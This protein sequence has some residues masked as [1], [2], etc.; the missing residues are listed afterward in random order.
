M[1]QRDVE[2]A[3]ADATVSRF[4]ATFVEP[5]AVVPVYTRPSTEEELNSL[6]TPGGSATTQLIEFEDPAD[7]GSVCELPPGVQTVKPGPAFRT[8]HCAGC[9]AVAVQFRWV[10]R[11]GEAT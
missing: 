11:K 8:A 5:P 4:A 2:A 10:R 6:R 9:V 1:E 3:G 7:F